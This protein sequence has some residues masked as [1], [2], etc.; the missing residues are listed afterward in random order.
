MREHL[1]RL[2]GERYVARTKLALQYDW[3]AFSLGRVEKKQMPT[4]Q[5]V[6]IGALGGSGTRSF[7]SVLRQAGVWMGDWNDPKTEDA[8]AMRVFLARWFDD[9]FASIQADSPAPARAVNAFYHATQIHRTE[10]SDPMIPWG[11]K[12]PRNMWMIPFYAQFFPGLKFIHVVR[13]GRDMALSKN[14]FLLQEHGDAVLG[15]QWRQ[16]PI[17]AQLDLWE[18]GNRLAQTSAER[19]LNPDN[20]LLI[21][22]EDLCTN[23]HAAVKNMFDFLE[24]PLSE[25]T[26]AACMKLISPSRRIGSWESSQASELENMEPRVFD[27]LR[28]FG[29]V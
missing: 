26:L 22:Y 24:V 19:Y 6:I 21:K 20:Y 29:Y 12:N 5:P 9:I 14:Q 1:K 16:N 25:Q 8:L 10:L 27:A 23:P 4:E 3:K 7:V 18:R 11:W 13:D 28:E 15:K 2:V 17:R